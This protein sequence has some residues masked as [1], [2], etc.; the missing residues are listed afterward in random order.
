MLRYFERRA[1]GKIIEPSRMFIHT[2]ARRLA[3][4]IGHC[5]AGL[6]TTWKAIVRFGAPAE[7][8]W[9]YHLE[10]LDREPDAFAYSFSQEF[11]SIRYLRL[12]GRGKRGEEVLG[13]VT[14]F[15][16]AGFACVFGFPVCTSMSNGPDVPFPTVFDRVRGGQAV[17][18]VG[19]DDHRRFRS[20]RGAL[21]I[22]NSWG[23]DWGEDGYAWL[24]YAYVC[25]ELAADFWTVLKPEW[26]ESEE[27]RRPG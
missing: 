11:N 10:R 5:D 6:R 23:R 14:S 9:P 3:D 7:E 12:D 24:P 13:T 8:H 20:E 22:R 1:E 26:L 18:A 17:M 19:Y 2:T 15:L 27:F 16:A 4:S 21:L 25:E